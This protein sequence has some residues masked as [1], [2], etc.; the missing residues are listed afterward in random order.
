MIS[1][2]PA[3]IG[4]FFR[5]LGGGVLCTV[6]HEIVCP[7]FYRFFSGGVFLAF[8][9]GRCRKDWFLMFSLRF[10]TGWECA[11]FLGWGA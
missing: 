4:I 9:L 7:V 8:A 10:C 1:K 6:K 3:K 11:F 2:D 5:I